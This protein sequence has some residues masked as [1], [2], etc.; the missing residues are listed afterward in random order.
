M[1]GI[2]RPNAALRGRP[3]PGKPKRIL[4]NVHACLVQGPSVDSRDRCAA[5]HHFR[6]RSRDRAVQ[7]GRRRI[8]SG[9]E[10]APAGAARRMAGA[11]QGRARRPRQG[12]SRAAVGAVRGQPDRAPLEQPARSGSG[13]LREAQGA[14][15]HHLARRAR[16]TQSG[17]ASLGRHRLS[18][19]D[20]PEIRAQGDREGR[21]RP[22]PGLGRRRRPCRRD[23]AVRLRGGDPAMVRW[24]DRAV[25][26]DRQRPRHPR[27]AD[28][29]RRLRL[30]RLGLH[31][32][33][34]GQRGGGLQA[35]DHR[36]DRRRHRL[37][38]PVHR[39]ARQLSE[40]VDRRGR[41]GS[42]QSADSPIRRR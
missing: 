39:R 12:A 27:G 38:Q 28:A 16:R 2:F 3:V 34:G 30:Y 4:P 1:S 26:R 13:A 35:D 7:G 42:R 14:D 31:R 32:H 5:V 36:L 8:V 10:R 9:A 17:R 15:D 19:R 22:D 18:R 33:H 20:Q 37:F 25:G 21:R 23:L 11:D 40:A 41:H 29:R 6:A 24:A